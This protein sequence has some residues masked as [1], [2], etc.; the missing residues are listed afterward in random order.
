MHLWH[1]KMSELVSWGVLPELPSLGEPR[2]DD[3]LF[4]DAELEL[5]FDED[6]AALCAALLLSNDAAALAAG[7]ET[8]ACSGAEAGG[9]DAGS[10]EHHKK[11][12]APSHAHAG[13]VRG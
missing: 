11:R 12:R 5:Q 3:V 2:L 8:A 1:L 7:P 9:A 10:S 6:E 4:A 13:T